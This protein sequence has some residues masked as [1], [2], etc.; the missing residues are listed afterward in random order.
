VRG[1]PPERSTVIPGYLKGKTNELPHEFPQRY[2][3]VLYLKAATSSESD[4]HSGRASAMRLTSPT[5]FAGPNLINEINPALAM[6]AT[7]SPSYVRSLVHERFT[8]SPDR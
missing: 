5:T 1:I 8:I 3:R 6:K 4:R 7:D 2:W